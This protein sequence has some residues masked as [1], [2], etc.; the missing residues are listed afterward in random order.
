MK[1]PEELEIQRK[2]YWHQYFLALRKPDE[3][4]ARHFHRLAQQLEKKRR[5]SKRHIAEQL[6]LL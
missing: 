3:L 6:S 2:I 4:A 1:F 5:L